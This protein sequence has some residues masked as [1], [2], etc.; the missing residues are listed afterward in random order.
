MPGRLT[1][2]AKF[3]V[4]DLRQV[5]SP[6]C[7]TRL[8]QQLGFSHLQMVSQTDVG[9]YLK[10]ACLPAGP[11]LTFSVLNYSLAKDIRSF[12][13]RPRSSTED[14]KVHP[15]LVINGFNTKNN[16]NDSSENIESEEQKN[17]HEGP[18]HS[19]ANHLIQTT[20]NNMFAS[21]E[22]NTVKVGQC[23]R[24]VLYN[25]CK[26]SKTIEMRH[27]AIVKR[28][29]GI[30]R[31]IRK[32]LRPKT[33]VMN[34]RKTTD[35]SDFIVTGGSGIASDSEVEDSTE[36]DLPADTTRVAFA[37]ATQKIGITLT[38]LGP[39]LTLRFVKAEEDV[40]SGAVLF[41]EYIKKSAE[42]LKILNKKEPELRAKRRQQKRKYSELL[43]LQAEKLR[44][45]KVKHSQQ[46]KLGKSLLSNKNAPL[47]SN[48]ENIDETGNPM[49]HS[50][51]N[52]FLGNAEGQNAESKKF[53]P[54]SFKRIRKSGSSINADSQPRNE[55]F[56]SNRLLMKNSNKGKRFQTNVMQKFHNSSRKSVTRT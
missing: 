40:C 39:R 42:D 47:M 11:T 52:H 19:K 20:L 41:H 33:R 9:T 16:S 45:D 46:K 1:P 44:N 37:D 48:T 27:Y 3:L 31:G 30:T 14:Y 5:M 29:A 54:F 50:D 4:Q 38:E 23:R 8:S 18:S 17:A 6:W 26:T 10:I 32:L 12:Q 28:P 13:K 22:I 56:S 35:V 53:N 49:N 2:S 21:I 34:L 24:V 55:N 7:V 51:E 15:L 36:F 43:E 25:Y